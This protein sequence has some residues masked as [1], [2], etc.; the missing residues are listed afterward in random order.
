MR[1]V[2]IES[3]ASSTRC[4]V[5]GLWGRSGFLPVRRSLRLPRSTAGRDGPRLLASPGDARPLVARGEPAVPRGRR[6]ALVAPA[7]RGRASATRFSERLSLAAVPVCQYMD[8]TGD[9]AVLGEPG[10]LSRGAAARRGAGRRLP[11]ARGFGDERAALRPLRS[12]H[13]AR[14]SATAATACR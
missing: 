1:D 6:A 12:G 10:P 11:A 2:M 5:A 14:G 13:H 7:E 8:V 4:S 9:Q 3:L